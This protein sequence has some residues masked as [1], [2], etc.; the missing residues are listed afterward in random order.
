[1]QEKRPER[2]CFLD[3]FLKYFFITDKLDRYRFTLYIENIV[4]LESYNLHN[5]ISFSFIFY[6]FWFGKVL[7]CLK[8]Y[9][10]F[11]SSFLKVNFDFKLR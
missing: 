10:V 5:C 6:L 7:F 8:Y 1:M 4:L 3:S 11:L 9:S 2:S